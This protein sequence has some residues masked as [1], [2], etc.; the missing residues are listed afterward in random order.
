MS[1]I[2]DAL[3]RSEK[4]RA[5]KRLQ[6]LPPDGQAAAE[7]SWRWWH[8]LLALAAIIAV[9]LAVFYSWSGPPQYRPDP[10]A[11]PGDTAAR[12]TVA[13]RKKAPVTVLSISAEN[14]PGSPP[15]PVRP[16]VD[17]TALPLTIRRVLPDVEITS[18]IYASDPGLRM[19][20]IDGVSRREGD[21]LSEAH[22]L[23]GITESGVI[24]DFQGYRYRL[25]VVED[26][27]QLD[28]VPLTDR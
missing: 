5:S 18:H 28:Q 20:K 24:L 13:A 9:N 6:Q 12:T 3:N 26:W 27:Q 15:V 16:T 25:D 7:S 23:V 11:K 14:S 17:L 8:T 1:Y 4:E 19:V 21:L 10:D 22:R 2:L